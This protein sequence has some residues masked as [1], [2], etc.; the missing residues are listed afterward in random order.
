[1]DEL[2]KNFK[3]KPKSIN[4]TDTEK[5]KKEKLKFEEKETLKLLDK[6]E[7]QVIKKN[8][9]SSLN[10][11]KRLIDT[12]TKTDKFDRK[13]L[14]DSEFRK[15]IKREKLAIEAE[16]VII[17]PKITHIDEEEKL[18]NDYINNLSKEKIRFFNFKVR[19]LYDFLIS[20]K[21]L[22]YIEI[23]IE[24]GFEDME[25][26]LEINEDYFKEREFPEEYQK[27]ILKKVASLRMENLCVPG[28]ETSTDANFDNLP[29]IG[30]DKHCCWNCLKIIKEKAIEEYFNEN[31]IKL[32]VVKYFNLV[33]LFRNMPN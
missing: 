29:P 32:K 31:I 2:I 33:L 9:L 8:K 30:K 18:E 7:S 25:S 28:I 12:L 3:P 15:T 11:T 24:D 20:I 10:N 5:M 22:R 13:L 21:L 26:I 6:L 19:E 23:F 1:M 17:D 14:D 27:R 4:K 16:P